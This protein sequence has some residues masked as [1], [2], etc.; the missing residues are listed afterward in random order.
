MPE[1]RPEPVREDFLDFPTAWR[2]HDAVETHLSPQCSSAQ[3][4][5]ALLCDCG[6]VTAERERRVAEQKAAR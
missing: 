6:A 4:G 5:G 3:T 1:P 2:L